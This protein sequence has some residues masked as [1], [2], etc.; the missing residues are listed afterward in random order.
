M[1][2]VWSPRATRELKSHCAYIA[3]DRPRAALEVAE[4]IVAAVER[5]ATFPES[6]ATSTDH[7]TRVLP[8]PRTGLLMIYRVN[9]QALWIVTVRHQM[10]AP[11]KR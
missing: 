8:V 2:V 11:F 10:Q 1:R 7:T 5:L 9:E 6:V 3:R 4:R